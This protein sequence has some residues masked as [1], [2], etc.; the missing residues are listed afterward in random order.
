M[1][2]KTI[3]TENAPRAV[4]PYSQGVKIGEWIYLSGQIP[5]DP[6]TNQVIRGTIEEQTEL[7]MTNAQR[8]LEAAGASLSNV[9][10]VTLFI[11]NMDEFGQI[12]NVYATFFSS[13]PPARS[14]VQ[15]ARLPK[16]VGIEAD[17]I[18]YM[19]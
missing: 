9:V 7:V 6:N 16:D 13:D 15:V 2:R 11:S 3:F 1:D 14:A 18:A 17:M 10:K 8:V 19:E 4:G 5:I 12:N